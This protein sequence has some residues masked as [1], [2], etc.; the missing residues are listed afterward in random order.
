MADD[1]GLEVPALGNRPGIHSA[2]WGGQ[3]GNDLLNNQKL[4]AELRQVP[5]ERR[6]A[7]YVCA[8]VVA[9][10]EGKVLLSAHGTCEGVIIDTP[11][12][13][14]GFGYDP[15]FYLPD[16]TCTMAQLPPREK[17]AISHRGRALRA[18]RKK[19][20]QLVES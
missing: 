2:R 6:Q 15:H 10:P 9:S 1:S 5:P 12:G 16:R 19:I 3:D 18:L 8:A 20:E 13:S 11:A 7:R 14:G 4:V 17:H